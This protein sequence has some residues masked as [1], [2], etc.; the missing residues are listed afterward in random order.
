M[1]E[2]NDEIMNVWFELNQPDSNGIISLTGLSQTIPLSFDKF[3]KWLSNHKDVRI[4]FIALYNV[5]LIVNID[6]NEN[7]NIDISLHYPND[8]IKTKLMDCNLNLTVHPRD[9]DN[10]IMAKVWLNDRLNSIWI[11]KE[12]KRWLKPQH[13]ERYKL[14]MRSIHTKFEKTVKI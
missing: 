9:L 6:A 11:R 7:L 3:V 14:G 5:S 12:L 13:K 1:E 8:I 10:T 4:S 2:T